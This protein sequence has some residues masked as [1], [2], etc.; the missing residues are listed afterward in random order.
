M[1]EAEASTVE[2]EHNPAELMLP[3]IGRY[4]EEPVVDVV[5]GPV[6]VTTETEPVQEAPERHDELPESW[7]AELDKEAEEIYDDIAAALANFA[8]TTELS[9]A[10]IE[11]GQEPTLL[12]PQ[13]LAIK[14]VAQVVADKLTE[15]AA[16]ERQ[17]AAEMI[18][19][20]V[21]AVHG[22]WL[23]EA[24]EDADP[25]LVEQVRAQLQEI[26]SS[27]SDVLGLEFD[28]QDMEYFVQAV[29]QLEFTN[30]TSSA[31]Q[32]EALDLEG[33]GTHEVKVA[34]PFFG[35]TFADEDFASKALGMFTLLCA[36]LHAKS[37]RAA[38]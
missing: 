4:Q 17:Q 3:S 20:M 18:K 37:L 9:D 27:L 6:F 5:D 26:V 23:L 16:D 28:A 33:V 35:S 10:Q 34:T 36:G 38:A 15:L 11:D 19:N 24:N 21:G 12:T 7:A 1:Y 22:L 31:E 30:G 25:Q 14:Q 29:L 8:Q 32:A 13:E 2:P